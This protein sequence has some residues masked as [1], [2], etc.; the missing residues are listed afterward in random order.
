MLQH[1]EYKVLENFKLKVH[2]ISNKNINHISCLSINSTS[3]PVFHP[4]CF[5]TRFVYQQ[6]CVNGLTSFSSC[7]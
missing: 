4:Q 6:Q 1:L 2:V 5:C 3:K 7:P